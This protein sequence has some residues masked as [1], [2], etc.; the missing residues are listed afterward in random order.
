M[1]QYID[2]LQKLKES[3]NYRSLPDVGTLQLF[4]LCSNDYMGIGS[5]VKMQEIFWKEVA[6]K[7][8]FGS[9]SSRLL[10]K[11][12]EQHELLETEI[13]DVF[14]KE[15]CLLFNSGFHA[16]AGIL[17]ALASDK[18]LIL[19]DKL[20]HAS[21]ID[22][23]KLGKADFMRYRH[24]DYNHL[25]ALLKKHR[26]N[27][28][29]VFIVS[30][31]IFSMDGDVADL[32]KLI[33]LKQEYNG[34]LYLDEAHALGVRGNKGLGCAEEQNCLSDL[35]FI[36]GTMGKAWASMGAF[37]V[38]KQVFKE[39]LINFSRPFIYSTALPPINV[40]WSRFVFQNLIGMNAERQYLKRLSRE[41]A[42]MLNIQS[43]S[44]IIPF[45]IG[46]NAEA[47][48]KS[49]L[50]KEYGFNALPVRYP[51]VPV[52]TARLRFSLSASMKMEQLLPIQNLLGI[53][54]GNYT[55]NFGKAEKF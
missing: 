3:D 18:D 39:T 31:S 45:V 15:S 48:A 36:V 54:S 46:S 27:Y 2:T 13:A 22:G 25:E 11:T 38:C 35:D 55:Q 33:E 47:I 7:H 5:N 53:A 16:N 50:L 29:R 49:M 4:D 52:N 51:T 9:C 24:L 28:Q 40:A 37:V 14:L 26:G 10:G 17:P 43:E 34:L 20:V 30:E 19:A 23:A 12:L 6:V 21:I 44:H 1:Q 41:F 8:S 32:H 42:G